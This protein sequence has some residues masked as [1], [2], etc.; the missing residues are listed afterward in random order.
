MHSI[1]VQ[2]SVLED[3]QGN[4]IH[5]ITEAIEA[6]QRGPAQV[7]DSETSCTH[8][9]SKQCSL[10]SVCNLA[11]H[12]HVRGQEAMSKGRYKP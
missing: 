5:V 8:V 6:A 7:R 3:G 12:L 9:V 2:R 11:G 10:A 1:I 4:R